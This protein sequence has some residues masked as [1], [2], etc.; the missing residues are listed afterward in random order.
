MFEKTTNAISETYPVSGAIGG[1][2]HLC[3]QQG[4]TLCRDSDEAFDVLRALSAPLPLSLFPLGFRGEQIIALDTSPASIERG[5]APLYISTN[6]PFWEWGSFVSLQGEHTDE[7]ARHNSFH[8]AAKAAKEAGESDTLKTE[9]HFLNRA[10]QSP[11][12][13]AKNLE[14]VAWVQDRALALHQSQGFDSFGIRLAD[15]GTDGQAWRVVG[16]ER[17]IANRVRVAVHAFHGA[18]FFGIS[19]D[20]LA[21]ALTRIHGRA[22]WPWANHLL[23]LQNAIYREDR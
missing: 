12:F 7:E 10:L 18:H 4:W 8:H 14:E 9:A 15:A 13:S 16:A 6:T 1:A 20:V 3:E 11:L 17:A 2:V 5:V 23:K 19:R 22:S 21:P